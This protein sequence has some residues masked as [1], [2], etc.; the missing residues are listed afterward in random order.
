MHSNRKLQVYCVGL[1]RQCKGY[2][3]PTI[4]ERTGVAE[5]AAV[6]DIDPHQLENWEKG[7]PK[8]GSV[9]KSEDWRQ[10]IALAKNQKDSKT[11]FVVSTPAD[12]HF[13]IASSALEAGF[14][15]YIDKPFTLS[16]QEGK[17]LVEKATNHDNG[18]LS[19]VVGSQ[20]RFET[21]YKQV[22][23]SSSKLGQVTNMHFHHHGT[24]S[25]TDP[26][27][28]ENDILIGT[29]YHIIDTAVWLAREL[30]QPQ[31]PTFNLQGAILQRSQ[32]NSS[33][34]VG[35]HALVASVDQEESFVI[36]LASSSLSPLN[37]VDELLTVTCL[38]GQVRL[39]RLQWPRSQEPGKLT[40]VVNR[41][42]AC[43][44]EDISPGNGKADRGA[45]LRQHINGL[46]HETL[47]SLEST[48]EAAL[49]TLEL[50]DAIREQG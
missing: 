43:N 35:F 29:G 20:R 21:V 9:F 30:R 26:T 36:S 22:L 16:Y 40:L 24:F 18:P 14:H 48:G 15:V 34:Y 47:M 32:E 4:C 10:L 3:L 6:C 38:N 1:G 49:P 7:H 11:L 50:I 19:I 42:G 27:S 17:T 28:Q 41:D 31:I 23:L 33:Q 12:L 13:E 39:A 2:L 44:A 8:Q 46:H 45:P 5:L 25:K 37:S